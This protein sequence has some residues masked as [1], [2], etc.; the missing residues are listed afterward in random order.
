[1]NGTDVSDDEEEVEEDEEE[2][3]IVEVEEGRMISAFGTSN[4][5]SSINFEMKFGAYAKP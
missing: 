1:M 5:C 4:V 2:A 3:E